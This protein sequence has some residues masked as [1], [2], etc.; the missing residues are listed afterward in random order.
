MKGYLTLSDLA[1]DRQVQ[2][3]AFVGG[4]PLGVEFAGDVREINANTRI[5][6]VT[7]SANCL[8]GLTERYRQKLNGK[9]KDFKVEVIPNA[10]VEAANSTETRTY[11]IKSKEPGVTIPDITADVFVNCWISYKGQFMGEELINERGQMKVNACR[12]SVAQGRDNVFAVGCH[13]QTVIHNFAINMEGEHVAK[14]VL[15]YATGKAVEPWEYPSMLK[16]AGGEIPTL[17]FYTKMGHNTYSWFNLDN[18][19]PPGKQVCGMCGF[20]FCPC[21]CCWPLYCVKKECHPCACGVCC[22]SPE[23]FG[24]S[25]ITLSMIE[26]TTAYGLGGQGKGFKHIAPGQQ[27]MQ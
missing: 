9:F 15:K 8:E 7:R 10:T 23:G 4:G 6:I 16:T 2:L 25:G 3:R 26:G 18:L 19:G 17:P 1:D 27:V 12:Q 5:V 24:A 20:P 22:G 21:I 13:D 11:Q 14:N